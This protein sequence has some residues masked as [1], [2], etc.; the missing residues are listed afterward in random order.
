MDSIITFAKE[1]VDLISLFIGIL[2]VLVAIA[3]V[4]VEIKNK[5]KNKQ[6]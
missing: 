1:N 2:G 6:P 4:Y 5:R 3:S